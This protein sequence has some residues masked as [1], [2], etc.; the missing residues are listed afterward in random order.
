MRIEVSHD[1][2]CGGCG[3][4]ELVIFEHFGSCRVYT[5]NH[6]DAHTVIGTHVGFPW[7]NVILVFVF[8]ALL[9][10]WLL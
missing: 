4:E 2:T 8:F 6:C 3:S 1:N 5:C 9:L 7:F 10:L